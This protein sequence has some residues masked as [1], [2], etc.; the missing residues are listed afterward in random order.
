VAKMMTGIYA[1]AGQDVLP[2]GSRVV[3]VVTG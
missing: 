2:G 3:A 1:L